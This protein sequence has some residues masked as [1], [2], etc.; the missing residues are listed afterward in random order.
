MSLY[1]SP[2]ITRLIYKCLR[3]EISA[4]NGHLG[5]TFIIYSYV[6]TMSAD[7]AH[8]KY[9]ISTKKKKH[10]FCRGPFKDHPSNVCFKIG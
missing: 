8:L 7:D 6:K 3:I 10:N 4:Y 5:Y 9:P 2:D 1:R